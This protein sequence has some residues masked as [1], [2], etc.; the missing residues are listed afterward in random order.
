[1]FEYLM[2]LEYVRGTQM[3]LHRCSV[4]HEYV[5]D[6]QMHTDRCTVGLVRHKC[7]RPTPVSVKPVTSEVRRSKQ[8]GNMGITADCMQSLPVLLKYFLDSSRSALKKN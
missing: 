2:M 7:V 5:R 6:T 1:M 4:G 3:R 8:H